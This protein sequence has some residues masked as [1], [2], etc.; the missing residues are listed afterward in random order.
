M[1]YLRREER[2]SVM[3]KRAEFMLVGAIVVAMAT[4]FADSPI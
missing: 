3:P 1:R 2:A 4:M